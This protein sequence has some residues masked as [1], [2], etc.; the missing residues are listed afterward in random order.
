M[1]FDLDAGTSI[2]PPSP[3]L[4]NFPNTT[5]TTTLILTIPSMNPKT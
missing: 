5:T 3:L 1:K 4:L 2:P